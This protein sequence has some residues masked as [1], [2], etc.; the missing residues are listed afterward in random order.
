MPSDCNDRL[1]AAPNLLTSKTIYGE[2]AFHFKKR[3]NKNHLSPQ[4][5]LKSAVL[6]NSFQFN[7][8]NINIQAIQHTR[9]G[10]QQI[11]RIFEYLLRA[12]LMTAYYFIKIYDN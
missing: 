5:I 7:Y 10:W 8:Q 3:L 11:Y 6:L 1:S 4:K 12:T 9:M 2:I